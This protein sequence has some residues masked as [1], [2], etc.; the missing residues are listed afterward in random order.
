MNTSS[1]TLNQCYMKNV[2]PLTFLSCFAVCLC[3]IAC[4]EKQSVAETA[5]AELL[6]PDY[7]GYKTQ[8]EYGEHLVTICGCNDCHTPKKMGAHGPEMDSSLMLSGHPSQLPAPDVD[9]K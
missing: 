9:V 4:S 6:K 1:N 5:S 8:V 2:Y 3:L 7:G